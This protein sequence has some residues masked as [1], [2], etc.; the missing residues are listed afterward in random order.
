MIFSKTYNLLSKK[1]SNN[2]LKLNLILSKDSE[3]LQHIERAGIEDG[4]GNGSISD[5][6][7]YIHNNNNRT[8][9]ERTSKE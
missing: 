7:T 1:S 8:E 3:R 9:L 5:D 6:D 2:A 4:R